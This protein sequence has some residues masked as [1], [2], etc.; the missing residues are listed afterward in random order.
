MEYCKYLK[1]FLALAPLL[2]ALCGSLPARSAET[3]AGADEAK[4]AVQTVEDSLFLTRALW[5]DDPGSLRDAIAKGLSPNAV[6]G[7]G[8]PLLF[9][10]LMEEA[11]KVA[12][13]LIEQPGI[14][15]EA[16]TPA[17]ETPLMAA[18]WRGN[19]EVVK[20]LVD[21]K[22][23]EVSKPGWTAL[24]YAAAQGHIE[25]VRYLFEQSAYIDA[26]SPNGTTPLMMAA[27]G[28]HIH[29]VKLLLDEGADLFLWNQRGLSAVD[30][31]ELGNQSEIAQGLASRWKKLE[32]LGMGKPK[33][34]FDPKVLLPKVEAPKP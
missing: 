32:A 19:L 6:D 23:A 31:A 22:S 16:Q 28:G 24:H 18:A 33:P 4:P 34:Q 8:R 3:A 5:V 26:A 1:F 14:D 2:A 9:A 13:M 21:G 30:F 10:A 20:L 12:K 11:T 7:Q 27:R 15:L 25:I 29:V 17:G